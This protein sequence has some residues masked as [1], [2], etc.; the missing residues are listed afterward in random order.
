MNVLKGRYPALRTLG[1]M[2]TVM[3]GLVGIMLVISGDIFSAFTLSGN[4]QVI[5]QEPIVS[6]PKLIFSPCEGHRVDLI[7]ERCGRFYPDP[8][9]PF[10]YI[11]FALLIPKSLDSDF[12][13]ASEALKK[14]T[15]IV[16][17]SGGPGDGGNT[18]SQKMDL[19]RYRMIDWGI[20]QPV[21]LWDARGNEGAWGYFHCDDYRQLTLAQFYEVNSTGETVNEETQV[22]QGCLDQWHKA[23]RN[24]GFSQFSSQQNAQD[25]LGLLKAL[26]FEQWHLMSVS[27]GSRIAQWLAFLAPNQVASMLLDSPYSWA[28]NSRLEHIKRW[29]LAFERFY[30]TCQ[31]NHHCNQGHAVKTL[32][33]RAFA[34]L[35]KQPVRVAFDLEGFKHQAMIDH[36]Q[37][38]HLF[39]SDLYWP[40][41][42]SHWVSALARYLEG[43]ELQLHRLVTPL[44]S[45]SLSQAANPWLYWMTECNDNLT[46]DAQA[47]NK[48][49]M[50]LG[51]GLGGAA[52]YWQGGIEGALCRMA[53][54]R[55]AIQAPHIDHPDTVSSPKIILWGEYDPVVTSEDVE[56]MVDDKSL[57]LLGVEHGHGLLYEE[58]CGLAWLPL[59]WRA[60]ADFVERHLERHLESGVQREPEAAHGVDNAQQAG[61]I[62]GACQLMI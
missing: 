7:N 54:A 1:L 12:V 8:T 27:Y 53:G 13:L 59:F 10:I 42:R 40:F 58:A 20:Q 36:I 49:L 34:K 43:D 16:N 62:F 25:I 55:P 60:P 14:Q 38:A 52:R 6:E 32:V 50:S 5:A 23:L 39:F 2:V 29:G 30:T 17:F 37:L 46:L 18:L 26:G 44:L 15:P 11:S 9:L 21:I 31:S 45:A 28:V 19:W 35:E 24:T 48:A 47:Y 61:K 22:V 56:Q 57:L 33:E 4:Q 41:Q 3:V 51:G